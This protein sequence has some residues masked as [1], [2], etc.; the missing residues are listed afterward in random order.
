MFQEV[1]PDLDR[2]GKSLSCVP[3]MPYGRRAVAVPRDRLSAAAWSRHPHD[4]P[5]LRPPCAVSSRRA[6]RGMGGSGVIAASVEV[7]KGVRY[8]A[9]TAPGGCVQGRDAHLPVNPEPL[10][11]AGLDINRD[12]LKRTRPWLLGNTP[13]SSTSIFHRALILFPC[14]CPWSQE[15]VELLLDATLDSGQPQKAK[16]ALLQDTVL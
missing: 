15:T 1:H 10:S 13:A 16:T 6:T 4:R 3:S 2:E 14:P 5:V 11:G 7:C 9:D 8:G 12:P